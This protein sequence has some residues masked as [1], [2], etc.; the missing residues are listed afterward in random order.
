LISDA[1]EHFKERDH[2]KTTRDESNVDTKLME[3]Q[4]DGVRT[5]DYKNIISKDDEY[6]EGG[7]RRVS[8]G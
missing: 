7:E 5:M 6:T 1:E 2:Y 8:G 4:I 3:E